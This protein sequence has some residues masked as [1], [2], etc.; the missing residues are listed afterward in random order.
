MRKYTEKYLLPIAMILGIMFHR[1]LSILSPVIPYLLSMMLFITYSRVKWSDIKLTKFHYILLSIQYVGSALIYLALRPFNE[2]LAQAAMICVLTAT[3][4]S[5]PVVAGILGGSI[6]ATAAYSIISNLS[7][8]FIAPVFL[9]LIGK[10][11]ETA[12]FATSFWHIFRSV[13]PILVLPFIVALLL[14]KTAPPLHRKIQSA[15]IVSFYLWA[16]A[17]TIVI[18]NITQY[19]RLQSDNNYTLEIIITATSLVICLFQFYFGRKIGTRFG[20]TIAGGQ[21]LGQKNTVLAIWL[22]QT[23]LNPLATLGPGMY[24]LWQNLVNSWQIWRKNR[25]S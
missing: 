6:A 7:V 4:T 18:G 3:A 22:A 23:Y 12:S 9:S 15:Q 20:R 13:I 5:A 16:V 14:R 17:L 2:I 8:A 10:S 25:K 11:G 24:V 1:Q 21:G 19:V